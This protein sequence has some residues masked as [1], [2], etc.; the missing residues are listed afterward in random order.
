MEKVMLLTF[1]HWLKW[2]IFA[3]ATLTGCSTHPIPDDVSR[4][5]T[6]DIVRNVRCEAKAGVREG[7]LRGLRKAGLGDIVPDTVLINKKDFEKI[8]RRDPKLAAKFVAYGES[9]IAYDFDFMINE[10]NDNNGALTFNIPFASGGG[11]TLGLDGTV[12][13]ERKGHRT[14]KTLE[15]FKDLA[16]LRCDDWVQPDRNM[17]HPLT[18]SIGVDNIMITFIEVSEI[19]GGQGVFSD[20]ITFTTDIHGSVKPTLVL[21]PVVDR[22]RLINANASVGGTRKDVHQVTI[23]L[24]FPQI[25]V[26]EA[27]ADRGFDSNSIS[28]PAQDARLRAL[29]R[30]CIATAE[31]R[32]DRFGTLRQIPPQYYCR[33]SRGAP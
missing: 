1:N 14:F 2:T 22:F 3:A 28:E 33:Q 17:L 26:R 8:N 31:A 10:N 4:Y 19:G 21:T 13:K 20:V 27:R 30:L 7:I 24:A 29:E 32:E 6:D 11:F 16:K 5:S 23:G 12:N 9:T 25:D 15:K 18:G